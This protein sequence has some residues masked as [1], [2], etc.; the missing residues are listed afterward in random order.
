MSE[1]ISVTGSTGFDQAIC[2]KLSRWFP[3]S[4]QLDA[5]VIQQALQ[6]ELG[7]SSLPCKWIVTVFS[8]GDWVHFLVCQREWMFWSI[9]L[10]WL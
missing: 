8:G 2:R 3:S 4:D 7:G 1:T 9:M 5:S 10:A 6:E